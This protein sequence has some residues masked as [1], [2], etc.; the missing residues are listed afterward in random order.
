MTKKQQRKRK[1]RQSQP[2]WYASPMLHR[3]RPLIVAICLAL[4]LSVT[5]GMIV[6]WKANT[7][8]PASLII[9]APVPSPTAPAL[10]K[11]YV[12]AGSSLVAVAD[13]GVSPGQVTD[14]AVWRLSGGSATWY[15]VNGETG[16]QSTQQWGTTGDIPAAGDYDGDAKTDFAVFR[17]STGTWYIQRSTDGVL[18]S[19]TWGV[20][21]DKPVPADYDGDGRSDIAVFRPSNLIWYI[22]NSSSSTTT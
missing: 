17:P 14:L 15:V 21:G 8:S 2:R 19:Q 12:Y 7:C 4:G 22:L 18:L 11:E 13:P 3:R 6:R 20:S 1:H 5:G 10:Q 9:P 16:S